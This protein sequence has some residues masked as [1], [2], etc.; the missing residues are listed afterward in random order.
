MILETWEKLYVERKKSSFLELDAILFRRWIEIC[1]MCEFLLLS[2]FKICR[3]LERKSVERDLILVS[4][5]EISL[6]LDKKFV[7]CE[8]NFASWILHHLAFHIRDGL[9]FIP[10]LML[11]Y[12]NRI[13][14][15]NKHVI[16]LT[17]RIDNKQS[18]MKQL[19]F[20]TRGNR[21]LG[22]CVRYVC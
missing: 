18:Y 5:I 12:G 14:R 6:D 8:D 13:T 21:S 17:P 15:Q 1:W 11:S 19:S 4:L 9:Q 10:S 16:T 3:D 22:E 2:L 7:E 20:I